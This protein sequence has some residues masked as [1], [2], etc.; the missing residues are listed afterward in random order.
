MT[1][2]NLVNKIILCLNFFDTIVIFLKQLLKKIITSM[3]SSRD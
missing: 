3:L 2:D 1:N